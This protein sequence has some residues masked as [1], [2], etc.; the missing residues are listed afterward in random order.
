MNII[1]KFFGKKEMF[2]KE[3]KKM[4]EQEEVTERR[5]QYF[6]GM[7]V[8]TERSDGSASATLS[9]YGEARLNQQGT[10]EDVIN[11]AKTFIDTFEIEV[12]VN[13]INRGPMCS[14][15]EFLAYTV[16]V[17]GV[18]ERIE[19]ILFE[20]ENEEPDEE[21]ETEAVQLEPPA[22]E[23]NKLNFISKKGEE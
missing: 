12:K 4:P 20:N 16:L 13:I 1:D 18:T 7:V 8:V 19:A 22:D 5:R 2:K 21:V 9:D 17:R 3:E 14:A 10:V 23:N 11:F 6:G 15:S